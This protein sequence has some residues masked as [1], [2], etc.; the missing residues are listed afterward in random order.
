MYLRKEYKIFFLLVFFIFIFIFFYLSLFTKKKFEPRI[1]VG[2]EMPNLTSSTLFNDQNLS[3]KDIVNNEVFVVNI[4]ASWC[5][6]CKIEHPF[7]IKIKNKNIKIIGINYKDNKQNAK[8]FLK[9]Y[10]NPYQEILLDQKGTLSI[11]LG[12]FGVPETFVIDK[13]FI[14]VEKQIGPINDEFIKKVLSLK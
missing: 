6:P 2:N 8:K 7:L 9:K 13:N 14:I 5:A 1:V 10:Q 11:N 3:L 12:A 4:F